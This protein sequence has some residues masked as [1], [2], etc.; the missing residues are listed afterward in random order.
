M[1][2]MVLKLMLMLLEDGVKILNEIKSSARRKI[3]FIGNGGSAGIASHCATDYSKNGD[4]RSLALNDAA[5]LTCLSND[6]S[7]EEVFSK[8]IEYHGFENDL[9]VAISSSGNSNNIVNAI[10]AATRKMIIITLSGLKDNSIKK[11]G[12]MNFY[13]NSMEYGFVE[14]L[15]LTV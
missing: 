14:I 3:A 8:Q 6:Y 10:E 11:L 5:T 7:Y 9:L 1:I 4:V 13:I 12:D 2:E 15:H